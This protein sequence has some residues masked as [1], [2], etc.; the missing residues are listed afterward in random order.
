MVL[1]PINAIMDAGSRH[2]EFFHLQ[3]KLL[4]RAALLPPAAPCCARSSSPPWP[5]STTAFRF[6]RAFLF[7]MLTQLLRCV[8]QPRKAPILPSQVS[9]YSLS[10]FSLPCRGRNL[11]F[12]VPA[13]VMF[14]YTPWTK[15]KH[16]PYF[17][18]LLRA[19]AVHRALLGFGLLEEDQ[20]WN[21]ETKWVIGCP[22]PWA[23]FLPS[24]SSMV[25]SSLLIPCI[26]F[27]PNSFVF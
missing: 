4:A 22:I 10:L 23:S 5:W 13:G 18:P 12:D 16:G 17:T 6:A 26:L 24:L 2:E 27:A 3:S 7:H 21:W 1:D 20:G 14:I 19:V 8:L 15:R 9:S 11:W 25:V